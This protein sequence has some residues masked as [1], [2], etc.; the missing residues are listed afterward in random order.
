[1]SAAIAVGQRRRARAR[2][3]S[4]RRARRRAGRDVLLGDIRV[5]RAEVAVL[6]VLEAAI[7]VEAVGRHGP[8][9]N[10]AGTAASLCAAG[11]AAPPA[12][13]R[14]EAS[15]REPSRRGFGSPGLFAVTVVK[16][17]MCSRYVTRREGQRRGH[18]SAAP[19]G[20]EGGVLHAAGGVGWT[21]SAVRKDTKVDAQKR[22]AGAARGAGS[23]RP[24][25]RGPRRGPRRN[26]R[27]EGG[28]GAIA[29]ASARAA[30]TCARGAASASRSVRPSPDATLPVS[31][32]TPSFF[33]AAS[34]YL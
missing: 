16:L 25:G 14:R 26:E 7:P 17:E 3:R 18:A 5:S 21:R 4:G 28:A 9:R 30:S 1:M 19:R 10:A 12:R 27:G 29:I 15:C 6:N 32:K 20:Q 11:G 31:R 22:S 8:L 13:R 34:D 33:L 23:P 24:V 2:R